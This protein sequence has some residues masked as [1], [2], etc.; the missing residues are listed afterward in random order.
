MTDNRLY[1]GGF[2]GLKPGDSLLPPAKTG[3][4]GTL[5]YL[6]RAGIDP[7]EHGME[8]DRNRDDRVY[9]TTD[10]ELAK[11]YANSWT[12][13]PFKGNGS[14]GALYVA[15]PVGLLEN[16]PDLP[17]ISFQCA[18]AEIISVYDPAVSMPYGKWQRLMLKYVT[19]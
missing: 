11:A 7:H 3:I 13:M 1:H 6:E 18:A 9:L 17:G 8:I 2:P 5:K 4:G 15:R 12:L 10:R 14:H 19:M 16:D